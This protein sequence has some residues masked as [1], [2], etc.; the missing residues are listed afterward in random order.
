MT[1]EIVANPLNAIAAA[2]AFGAVQASGPASLH[3][4]GGLEP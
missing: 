1:R 2:P 3:A 4:A